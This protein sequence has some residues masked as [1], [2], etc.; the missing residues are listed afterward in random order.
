MEW[1]SQDSQ[2]SKY[3]KYYTLYLIS[4]G[5]CQGKEILE[6]KEF[7]IELISLFATA[8]E[9]PGEREIVEQLWKLYKS[10][11]PA[12]PAELCLRCLISH[13]IKIQCHSLA[14]LYGE[15]HM[16]FDKLNDHLPK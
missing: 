5:K 14:K 7:L 9:V 8:E 15:K 6:A 10:E 13:Y 16:S 2:Y 3:L 4:L 12:T 11:N 1:N